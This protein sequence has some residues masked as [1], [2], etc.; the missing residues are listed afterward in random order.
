MNDNKFV[1]LIREKLSGHKVA[2]PDDLWAKISSQLP[3]TVVWYKR[4]YVRAIAAIVLLLL[5]VA[6]FV[7]RDSCTLVAP[8]SPHEVV[9]E[10]T[11]DATE[12]IE[13]DNTD[14]SPV[15]AS[16]EEANSKVEDTPIY[17]AASSCCCD[18]DDADDGIAVEV[19]VEEEKAT[20]SLLADNQERVSIADTSLAVVNADAPLAAYDTQDEDI[21][22]D[23]AAVEYI[24]HK[25]SL[26]SK[27]SQFFSFD[28]TTSGMRT[29][30]TPFDYRCG[31]KGELTFNH[32]MPLTVRALFEKRFGRWGIGVG[33]SYTYMVSEYAMS[34][35]VRVGTQQLHYVGIPIHASFEIARV[36][37]FSFYTALGAQM[38]INTAGLHSESP[39][40]YIYECKDE[41]PFRDE[42][43]QFSAQL[44]LGAAFE[45]IE[46]FDIFVEP[47]LGYY[48]DSNSF[49]RNIWSDKPLNCSLGFGVR[50]WF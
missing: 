36:N 16:Q 42:K 11:I 32:K 35:K 26:G 25:H 38:D 31:G 20:H 28:A 39:E 9:A 18:V 10:E 3:A 41:I 12:T 24:K 27:P 15:I 7:Y 48:F 2:V 40:S 33:V 45:V 4:G 13:I 43:L 8:S 49:V 50:A 30:I 22:F 37:K 29:V 14:I 44:R 47:T 23:D 17:V 6:S 5:V 46:H 34:N 1:K 21:V 19:V